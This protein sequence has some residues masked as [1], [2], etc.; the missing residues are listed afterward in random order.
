MQPAYEYAEPLV[1]ELTVEGKKVTR[2]GR[3][4]D[5]FAPE[6]IHFSDCIL[7]GRQPEPSAE[8]GAQD[9]RI[10]EA[11]YASARRGG[12]VELA[13]F[14]GDPEPRRDQAMFRPPVRKPETVHSEPPHD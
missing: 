8:E 7:K 14:A 2:R 4:G 11:L 3:K 10:V 5:Q 6:L 13:S 12:T 1:C 9:V